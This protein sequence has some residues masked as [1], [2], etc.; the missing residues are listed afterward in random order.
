MKTLGVEDFEIKQ[1]VYQLF[2]SSS[3][4]KN[5]RIEKTGESSTK[6]QL[7][8]LSLHDLLPHHAT[9]ERDNAAGIMTI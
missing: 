1:H 3:G 2:T 9:A 6:H 8:E 7:K 5:W 4:R